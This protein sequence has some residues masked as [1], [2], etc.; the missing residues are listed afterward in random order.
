MRD[1]LSNGG[2]YVTEWQT[3][4]FSVSSVL[5]LLVTFTLTIILSIS[6]LHICNLRIDMPAYII[7]VLQR[8]HA[9]RLFLCHINVKI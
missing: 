6:P 9:F 3:K 4:I 5:Y 2:G 8:Q 1:L 7:V